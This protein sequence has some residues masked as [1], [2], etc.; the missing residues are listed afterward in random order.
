MRQLKTFTFFP[1]CI[2]GFTTL[3]FVSGFFCFVFVFH[4]YVLINLRCRVFPFCSYIFFSPVLYYSIHLS[5]VRP[6]SRYQILPLIYECAQKLTDKEDTRINC[7]CV[8]RVPLVA[9]PPLAWL[10]GDTL[11]VGQLFGQSGRKV[12]AAPQP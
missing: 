3:T 1:F 9:C 4:I 2:W 6:I 11:W 7:F 5:L 12:L 8:L 10:C